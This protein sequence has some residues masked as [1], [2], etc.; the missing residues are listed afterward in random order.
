MYRH[1]YGNHYIWNNDFGKIRSF[2]A[3]GRLHIPWSWTT[4]SA[5]VENVQNYIYFNPQC[6]PVQHPGHIQIFSARLRQNLRFG[7]WNWD[8]TLTY[9]ATSDSDILPLPAFTIY[10]NMYLYFKGIPRTDSS[11]W[12]GLQLLY[13]VPGH[14]VSA[15][16]NGIP[17]AGRQPDIY[18]WI[19]FRERVSDLQALQGALL[20]YV[21]PPERALVFPRQ[22]LSSPLP[23]KPRARVP[24]RSIDRLRRLI[25][26]VT[27]H[28][29]N[30]KKNESDSLPDSFL[31]LILH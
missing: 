9:Q 17:R 21:Q 25:A 30:H 22:F 6:L 7:I 4:L 16:H 20:R 26:T 19:C 14:D 24:L 8:N 2:R 27:K 31:W 15:R 12:R 28:K 11:D 10:S 29:L 23:P 3:E 18:R 5:G 13:Q 1:Y